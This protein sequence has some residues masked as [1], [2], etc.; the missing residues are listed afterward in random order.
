MSFKT[1]FIIPSQ[2]KVYGVRIKPS[3]P[4]LGI[5]YI[6]AVLEKIGVETRILDVDADGLKINDILSLIKDFKPQIAGIT[7]TTPLVKSA[8]SVSAAIKEN[9]DIPIVLGGIHATMNAADC[10][11]TPSIDFVAKGE[12]EDTMRDLVCEMMNDRPDFANVK[13]LYY[14]VGESFYFGGERGLIADLDKIPFPARHLL[15]N[16][17]NY[18]PPDAERLPVASIMTTRGCPGRCTYCCTKDIFKDR[19]RMRGIDNVIEEIDKA[20]GNFRVK[21]IHIADDAFNVNKARTLALCEAIRKRNYKVNFEFLNGLRADVIDDDILDAFRSIGIK[22]VGFGVESADESILKNVKKNI[23]PGRVMTAVRLA[24]KKGFKTW[25]F[26]MLG[27][28]GET[29][30]TI[31]KSLSFAKKMD[32][33][34]AKFLIFKPYPGSEIYHEINKKGFID[35]FDFDNYGVYTRPVHRLNGL[36]KGDLLRW[37]KR[38][39]REFYLRP[40]KIWDHIRRQRS[41]LQLRLT[42]TGFLFVCF[43]IFKRTK[44]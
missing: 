37:Q 17:S 35:D 39:F 33:D 21:E 15:G 28:P 42:L 29:D 30:G 44:E 16:L 36:A 32:P 11:Q 24:K 26:F 4:P 6:S 27:L 18:R 22:N 8:L 3:Y 10:I 43:N 7:A 5:L 12:S 2:E 1:L 40:K 41:L 25:A 38:A 13:G 9:F 19:Y 20:I 31:R 14:R 34:F 23:L